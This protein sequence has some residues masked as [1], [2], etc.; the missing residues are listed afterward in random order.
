MAA[1]RDREPSRFAAWRGRRPFWGGVLATLGG[2]E[3]L[4]TQHM[5]MSIALHI[6][7]LGLAGFLLPALLIVCGLL[8][9]FNPAQRLFYSIVGCLLALGTWI[10]S[11]LGGFV[12]GLLLGIVGCC[13][14]FGWL[15]DQ[16]PRR[17]RIFRRR[18]PRTTAVS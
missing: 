11:N 7:M 10:T 14:T 17:R 1:D 13:M 4:L 9:L 5:P 15:P 2:G 12:I 18:R 8:I 16:E 6:G 3:I